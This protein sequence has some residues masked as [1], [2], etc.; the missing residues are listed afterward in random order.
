M[1]SPTVQETAEGLT[2]PQRERVLWLYRFGPSIGPRGCVDRNLRALGLAEPA[3][4]FGL[5]HR[6]TDMGRDVAEC[7][8]AG[9][10]G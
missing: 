10:H 8:K 2:K 4:A 6:L 5:T 7:L 3:E 9:D 1:S